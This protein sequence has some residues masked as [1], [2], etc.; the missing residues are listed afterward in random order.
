MIEKTNRLLLEE[1][2]IDTRRI[3]TTGK[4]LCPQCSHERRKKNDP[5]LSIDIPNG[6]YKCH[7]CDWKGAVYNKP[8]Y[9]E[10]L[11]K[12]PV[13]NNRTELPENIVNWFFKRGI[14]QQT[15]IDFK[16]TYA[17]EWMPQTQK[18]E[19]TIQFN[20]F[21][22]G[23]LINVK[24]RDLNKNFKLVK[25]AELVL[26]NLDAIKDESECIICEGEIDAMSWHE[27]GFK[28]VVSVPNGASKNQRLEYLDNC[29]QY[30]DNKTKIYLSSDDDVP[31]RELR[32]ELSRRFGKERCFKLDFKG[33]KDA[34]EYLC[35]Y[36]A[37]ALED[38]FNNAQEYPIEGVFNINDV[39]DEIEDIYL[40]GLPEGDK[41]G[42]EEFDKHLRFMPSELT[43]VTGIPGHGKS[44]MLDQIALGLSINSDWTFGVFSPESFPMQFYYTRLIKRLLGKKFSKYNINEVERDV[45]RNWIKDRF[46]LIFPTNEG[47]SLDTIL[48][49]AK[50]LV[51]RKGIKGLIIDPWNRIES[52]I[53][54]GYNEVKWI[55]EQLAK[56]VN[57]NQK[58]GVHTFLVA[59]P[60]K[61]QKDD[62]K[63]NYQVPNLYSISG[64]AH[65]FNMT[66]NGFTVFRNFSTGKTE[67]HFQKIKWEH[68][69]RIGMVEY[70]YCEQNSRFYRDGDD[71]YRS[72]LTTAGK[73]EELA[74]TPS[75][76][77]CRFNIT[78]ETQEAIF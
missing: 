15:L 21:R 26:Y 59:H 28:N 72:W 74:L 36:G 51:L 67:V 35:R 9:M 45:A 16:I 75:L 56:I 38:V 12:R 4:T 47:F 43:M 57:F 24:Y 71:P 40:N 18:E 39:W 69:G 2:G 7:N 13:L 25:D 11:Y 5:C 29:F 6:L 73:Q 76:I 58:T 66:Q 77:G 64:S 27:A 34:N 48:E 52:T 54:N 22:D 65:F 62:D 23:E 20:Y 60:T 19:E 68:L 14:T 78:T 46:H 63:I 37:G 42:D 32:E 8:N 55:N 10:K 44:I 3:K 33:L 50:Q 61:M 70:N 53:P 17:R 31:G 1:L 41:T 30:F 49:K